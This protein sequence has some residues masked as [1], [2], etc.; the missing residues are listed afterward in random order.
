MDNEMVIKRCSW[1]IWGSLLPLFLYEQ[2]N[3]WYYSTSE[4]ENKL[5]DE[6]ATW[7]KVF[8]FS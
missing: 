7:Y 1:Q 3:R 8:E 4:H 6:H 5:I 2:M